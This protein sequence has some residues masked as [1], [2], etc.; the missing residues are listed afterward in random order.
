M[1]PINGMVQP[2]VVPSRPG[3]A[4]NQ[5]Q[6]LQ[7]TVLPAQWKHR[8]AWP[9]QEPV[10]TIKHGLTVSRQVLFCSYSLSRPLMSLCYFLFAGLLQSYQVSHGSG[11]YED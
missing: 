3:R 5:L 7:R 8:H 1:E 9:F 11:N 10:D 6:F 4:T 2:P